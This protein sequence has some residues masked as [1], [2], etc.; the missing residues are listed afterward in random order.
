MNRRPRLWNDCL[1]I[2]RNAAIKLAPA[3]D[4]SEPWWAEAEL[5]WISRGRQC[6]QLVAWFGGLAKSPGKRRA[7]VLPSALSGGFGSATSMENEGRSFVGEPNLEPAVASQ[8][9]RYLF[10][11]DA[12]I[13][14]AKLEG[15]LAAAHGLAAIS[16]GVAYFTGDAPVETALVACFEVLDVL[17]YRTKLVRQWLAERGVGRLEVKKRGVPLDPEVVRREL[18]AACTGSAEATVI[19]MRIGEKVMAVMARRISQPIAGN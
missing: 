1:A 18:T 7:T 10:E 19:L 14:A 4:L 11:P 15:A 13:L 3:A 5:E 17:P 2:N 6:R 9:G 8:I 16:P 12:A